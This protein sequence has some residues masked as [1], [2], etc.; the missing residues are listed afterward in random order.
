[1]AMETYYLFIFV[2]QMFLAVFAFVNYP[3]LFYFRQS[4]YRLL[5][6]FLYHGIWSTTHIYEIVSSF[7]TPTHACFT[8]T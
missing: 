7:V 5:H 6:S 4:P 3:Y 2:F 1:M 8:V